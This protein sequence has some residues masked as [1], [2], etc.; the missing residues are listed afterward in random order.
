MPEECRPDPDALLRRLQHKEQKA[1][2]RAGKLKIFVGAAAGVGKTYQMLEEAQ[3]LKRECV[4]VVIALVETH[5]RRETELLLEGQEIIARLQIEH[6][7]IVLEEMD[8]DGVLARRP[9]IALVD[10]LAH[11]NAPGTRHA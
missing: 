8:L 5:K 4:D 10:E 11:T 7:G 3:S 2:R 6:G 9:A 1:E